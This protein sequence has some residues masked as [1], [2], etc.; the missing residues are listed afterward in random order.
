M[1]ERAADETLAHVFGEYAASVHEVRYSKFLSL[2]ITRP[3]DTFSSRQRQYM[4]LGMRFVGSNRATA[5][6]NNFHHC[7]FKSVHDEP[8]NAPARSSAERCVRSYPAFVCQLE[9]LG[10]P[11]TISSSGDATSVEFADWDA[12]LQ[13]VRK[14]LTSAW[15]AFLP[16]GELSCT[17][18]SVS[19][20]AKPA[21]GQ[22]SSSSR[23][24]KGTE[25]TVGALLCSSYMPVN[26]RA[27]FLQMSESSLLLRQ[28]CHQLARSIWKLWRLASRSPNVA[29]L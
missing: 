19:Q 22:T 11:H 15:H 14:A 25:L 7:L 1:Q 4:Y 3:H 27:N 26:Q 28:H 20:A 16:P 9:C 17:G 21:G 13:P 5:L 10:L 29:K 6:I 2:F 24:L 18:M 12:V 23:S 8:L